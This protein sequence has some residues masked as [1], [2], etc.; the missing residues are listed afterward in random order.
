[1]STT[2]PG[3]GT[4]ERVAFVHDGGIYT[5]RYDGT[6]MQHVLDWPLEIGRMAWSPG[7]DKLAV[8]LGNC[9]EECR[10]DLHTVNLDGTGLTN[11]TPDFFEERNP[12]WSAG[13][14]ADRI[15]LSLATARTT[16]GSSA[17]TEPVRRRSRSA[18]AAPTPGPPGRR[19][20]DHDRLPQRSGQ[21]QRPLLHEAGR[22]RDHEPHGTSAGTSSSRATSRRSHWM[23]ARS[24]S[25]G[26]GTTDP[27]STGCSRP[28]AARC[29]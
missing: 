24:P 28:A 18:R 19:T 10:L 5:I 2:R 3:P 13:R 16:S 7:G 11:L 29:G 4:G 1:M 20:R 23:E 17:R 12:T 9:D 25:A 22:H 14:T 8:T 15:R 27:A 6:D 21:R 26:L